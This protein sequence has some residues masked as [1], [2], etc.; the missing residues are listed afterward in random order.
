MRN[1]LSS[2]KALT[3]RTSETEVFGLQKRALDAQRSVLMRIISF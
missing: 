2:P 3:C 1:E